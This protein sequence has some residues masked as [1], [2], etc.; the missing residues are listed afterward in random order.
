MIPHRRE[1]RTGPRPGLENDCPLRRTVFY[2]PLADG[3]KDPGPGRFGSASH[4]AYIL[5]DT[6]CFKPQI[7]YRACADP[8]EKAQIIRL[9]GTYLKVSNHMI[10]PVQLA[11]KRITG[12]VAQGSEICNYSAVQILSY[13]KTAASGA[14]FSDARPQNVG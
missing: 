2:R 14:V 13:N 3:R 1:S 12:S 6:G 11:V 5:P 8:G 9:A 7:L 4:A 10:R